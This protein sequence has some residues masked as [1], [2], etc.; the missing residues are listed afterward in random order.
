MVETQKLEGNSYT[1]NSVDEY[2]TLEESEKAYVD[3]FIG[4]QIK[5]LA[6]SKFEWRIQYENP[7]MEVIAYGTYT[8][9]GTE[10][11]FTQTGAI[12]NGEDH[13]MPEDLRETYGLTIKRDA[14]TISITTNLYTFHFQASLDK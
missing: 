9:N 14:L 8:Q 4:T 3:P 11:S 1:I 7:M 5:F 13:T 12:Q 6:E 2:D 10:G